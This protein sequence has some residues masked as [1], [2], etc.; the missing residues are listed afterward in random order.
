MMGLISGSKYMIE[1]IVSLADVVATVAVQQEASQIV[2]MIYLDTL[3]DTA[4][5][6]QNFSAY[7]R[8]NMV[9]KIGRGQ[10]DFSKDFW[11]VPYRL[12]R[13]NGKLIVTSAGPDGIFGTAD[14]IVVGLSYAGGETAPATEPA[15][16][17]MDEFRDLKSAGSL[18][19]SLSLAL[20]T[21]SQRI[22]NQKQTNIQKKP[23]ILVASNKIHPYRGSRIPAR[24]ANRKVA[25]R[26]VA[27]AIP[28]I[29]SQTN[30]SPRIAQNIRMAFLWLKYVGQ[31]MGFDRNS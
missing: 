3:D 14:D 10:R 25:S 11:G 23:K 18:Q 1:K 8:K 15:K 9:M 19:S 4:P 30:L 20:A 5:T 28:T 31:K 29:Q 26:R 16:S 17:P 2:E 27:S 21:S 12:E 6:P 24:Y 13:A 22:K 7:L